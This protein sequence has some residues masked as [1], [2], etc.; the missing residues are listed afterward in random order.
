MYS[1][2]SLRSTTRLH[3][4]QDDTNKYVDDTKTDLVTGEKGG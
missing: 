4:A 3:F 1:D 2:F